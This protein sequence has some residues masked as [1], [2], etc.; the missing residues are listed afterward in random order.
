VFNTKRKHAEKV[1]QRFHINYFSYSDCKLSISLN[2]NILS[3]VNKVKGLGLVDDIYLTF[4]SHN[5]NIVDR[6]FIRLNFFSN[7]LFRVTSQF[8]VCVRPILEHASCLVHLVPISDR[9]N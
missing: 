1:S 2:S 8:V 5:D 7:V 6:A 4:H 3:V 9:A